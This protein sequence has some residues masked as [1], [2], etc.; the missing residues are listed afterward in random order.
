MPPQKRRRGEPPAPPLRAPTPE[1]PGRSSFWNVGTWARGVAS[2]QLP[3]SPVRGMTDS[4]IG[5]REQPPVRPRE[6]S[7]AR[8]RAFDVP[9]AFPEDKD[10]REKFQL[11]T[12]PARVHAPGAPTHGEVGFWVR[13]ARENRW[14]RQ[15]KE[16]QRMCIFRRTLPL[17]ELL[18]LSRKT[19]LASA[20]D[21]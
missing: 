18:V 7:W 8:E 12:A 5:C 6:G 13:E 3:R 17:I 10:A 19:C 11:V 15:E 16:D 20:F 9:G 1:L 4:P 21:C 14:R 2:G